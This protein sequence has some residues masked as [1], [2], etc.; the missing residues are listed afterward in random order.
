MKYWKLWTLAAAA[1]C[2][3][4]LAILWRQYTPL[5]RSYTWYV[6]GKVTEAVSLLETDPTVFNRETQD[7]VRLVASAAADGA[8]TTPEAQYVLAAQ[9]EREGDF[10]AAKAVLRKIIDEAGEWSW[11]Y[12]ALGV[13]LA[14]SGQEYLEEA[15]QL[16]RKAVEL[17]PDWI[18]PYNS[19]SVVLRLLGRLEEAEAASVQAIEL[20]PYDV[21]AHNNYANLLVVQGRYSEAETH[22]QFA[23]ESEPDNPKPPYNL[24]C[25]YSITGDYEQACDYLEIAVELSET[26]RTDAAIDPYFDPMRTDPRFQEILFGPPTTGEEDAAAP[27]GEPG[28]TEGEWGPGET[29]DATEGEWLPEEEGETPD[30]AESMETTVQPGEVQDSTGTAGPIEGEPGPEVTKTPETDGPSPG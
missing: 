29:P 25:L 27:G 12:V 4:L 19:L 9:Y 18:R 5:E 26:S 30:E 16:L 21:A 24:A 14:R 22:Y 8:I 6:S 7:I 28:S 2:V 17:Q 13:L 15:E 1:A 11:P 3:A 10:E 20:A 23:M